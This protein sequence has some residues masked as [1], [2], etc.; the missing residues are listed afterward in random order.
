MA[1]HSSDSPLPYM[2]TQHHVH[3]EQGEY[4]LHQAKLS[5]TWKGE[6]CSN[7]SYLRSHAVL[8][9]LVWHTTGKHMQPTPHRLKAPFPLCCISARRNS[10]STFQFFSRSVSRKYTP[11]LSQCNSSPGTM[12]RT[13]HTT[14]EEIPIPA[15]KQLSCESSA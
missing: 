13:Y 4:I 11:R 5:P 1:T 14:T 10:A 9:L 2:N 6:I 3:H 8:C 7:C 15:A 12:L